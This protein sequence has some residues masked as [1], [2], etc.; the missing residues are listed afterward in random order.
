MNSSPSLLPS[1]LYPAGA[2]GPTDGPV[3]ASDVFEI[4]VGCPVAPIYQAVRVGDLAPHL[5]A[6]GIATDVSVLYLD[7]SPHTFGRDGKLV[8]TGIASA[9]WQSGSALCG[10]VL[11]LI[12][13]IYQIHTGNWLTCTITPAAPARPKFEVPTW[14]ILLAL[15]L[16]LWIL[17]KKTK[18]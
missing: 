16:G 14:V 4:V 15:G 7:G 18:E 6:S 10:E 1:S 13:Q 5:Y 2:A 9:D 17:W 11:K 3:R 12:S 8:I